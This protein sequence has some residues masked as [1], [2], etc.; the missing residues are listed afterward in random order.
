MLGGQ[1]VVVVGQRLHAPQRAGTLEVHLGLGAQVDDVGD[2]E[3]VDEAGDVGVA[4]VLEVVGP[5][6]ATAHGPAAAAGGQAADVTHVDEAVEVD[7]AVGHRVIV[8]RVD[9]RR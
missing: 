3:L 9:G 4:E 8:G 2:T 5:D 6:E 7:P 1:R